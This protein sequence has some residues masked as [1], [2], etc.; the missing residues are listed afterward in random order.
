MITSCLV[1]NPSFDP[2]AE[3]GAEATTSASEGSM[4]SATT[5]G[6]TIGESTSGSGSGASGSSTSGDP[7]TTSATSETS[8]TSET[9][10]SSSGGSDGCDPAQGLVAWVVQVGGA[11]EQGVRD[12]AAG[13]GGEIYA[14]GSYEAELALGE[15]VSGSMG[16]DGFV[17]RFA[18]DG[19][20]SWRTTLRGKG[21][22]SP[23]GVA[24]WVDGA[25]A[26]LNTIDGLVVGDYEHA[27]IGAQDVA[28]VLF[29]GDGAIVGVKIYGGVEDD[30]VRSIAADADGSIYLTGALRGAASF[31]GSTLQ[32]E[33]GVPR[34]YAVKLSAAGDLLWGQVAG[35]GSASGMSGGTG[36]ALAGGGM[37]VSGWYD[38]A[39]VKFGGKTASHSG[40]EDLLLVHVGPLGEVVD[41]LGAGL[42]GKQRSRNVAGAAGGADFVADA[43]FFGSLE[44]EDPAT[45]QPLVQ[46]SGAEDAGLFRFSL[47]MGAKDS[48]MPSWT[49]HLV[50]DGQAVGEGV[51]VG[52]DGSAYFVATFSGTVSLGG[53]S[54]SAV[55]DDGLLLKVAPDGSLLAFLAFGGVGLQQ[56]EH[57]ALTPAGC[58]AVVGRYTEGLR[59]G[60]GEAE[61]TQSDGIDG[62]VALL[63]L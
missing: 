53:M 62:F 23:T 3:S 19:A 9:S 18:A 37:I 4:G 12:V 6:G 29:G 14:S 27:I 8:E 33:P 31:G 15:L 16:R 13:P 58:V 26:V 11:G 59:L 30:E 2:G 51:A 24:A 46:A 21:A 1:P 41:V 34:L 44:I 48:F 40:G 47:P 22:Q 57:L 45:Q 25:A 56:P 42:A 63:R 61:L 39:S 7:S 49:K 35:A 55:G 28:L 32:G 54:R 60:E 17:A 10:G 36:V 5:A 43:W 38:A 20:L 52:A 50:G